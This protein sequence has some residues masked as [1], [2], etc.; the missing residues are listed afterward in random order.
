[1]SSATHCLAF[2]AYHHLAETRGHK[3]PLSSI[4]HKNAASAARLYE[5]LDFTVLPDAIPLVS[6]WNALDDIERPADVCQQQ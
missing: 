5:V 6:G 4:L 1:M 3:L 2:D